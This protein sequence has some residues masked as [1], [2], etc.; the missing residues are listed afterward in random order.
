MRLTVYE[1]RGGAGFVARAMPQSDC[2]AAKQRRSATLSTSGGSYRRE[3][4]SVLLSVFREA[5]SRNARLQAKAVSPL[6]LCHRSPKHD[7]CRRR[8]GTILADSRL[9][10]SQIRSNQIKAHQGSSRLIKFA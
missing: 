7:G 9:A 4:S 6:P 5:G 3:V 1:R 2:C 10:G 8:V